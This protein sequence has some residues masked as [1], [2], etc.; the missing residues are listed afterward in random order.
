MN[1]NNLVIDTL[2]KY[3]KCNLNFNKKTKQFTTKELVSYELDFNRLKIIKGRKVYRVVLT[4]DHPKYGKRGTVGGWVESYKNLKENAWVAE[5]AAV[6]ENAVLKGNA[7]A[8]GYSLIEENAV[9][10]DNSKAFNLATVKGNARL[11][12]NSVICGV[13][14]AKGCSLATDNA[15]IAGMSVIEGT[16]V[17]EG[18]G[19]LLGAARSYIGETKE[20]V[21]RSSNNEVLNGGNS[22]NG[23]IILG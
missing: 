9:M 8:G 10:E 21:N 6:I 1:T 23:Y 5:E 14:C 17:L 3:S 18:D 7:F 4:K 22:R 11:N 15:T 12:K 2:I 13:G 20:Y 16:A 19:K